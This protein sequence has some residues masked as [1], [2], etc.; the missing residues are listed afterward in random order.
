MGFFFVSCSFRNVEDGFQWI[1]TSVYGPMLANLKEDLWEELGSVRSLWLG[2][3]CIGGDFNASISLSESNKG[4]RIT[5]AMRR[6]VGVLNDLGVRDLPLQGGPFTWS[7]GNNGQVMSRIDGFLVSGNWESYFSR[8]IQSTL[9]RPVSDHFPILLDGG[10]IRLG[11]SP[12]RFETMW[13]KS[14]GFKDLLKG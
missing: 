8:V 14:E 1:F 4:G 7:G 3:W 6:F 11:S 12:F 9:P 13:L 10:G 2:P 5:Q